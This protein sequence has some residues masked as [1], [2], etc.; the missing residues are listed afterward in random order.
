MKR[1]VQSVESSM[2]LLLHKFIDADRW[3]FDVWVFHK[4]KIKNISLDSGGCSYKLSTSSVL[5]PRSLLLVRFAFAFFLWLRA[6]FELSRRNAHYVSEVC[7]WWDWCEHRRKDVTMY[8]SRVFDS[9]DFLDSV[10]LYSY[11]K[12]D[13]WNKEKH[14]WRGVFFA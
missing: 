14:L 8:E 11:R 3:L 2:S 9:M 4:W 1:L 10:Y 13:Y 5:L 12:Y 7:L 6:C